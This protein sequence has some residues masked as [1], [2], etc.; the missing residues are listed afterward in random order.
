MARQRTAE[1][2]RRKKAEPG[3]K[4]VAHRAP[5]PM[6]HKVLLYLCFFASGIAG[7]T[8]EIVWSKYLSYLLGNSIYGVAT[9]V[10]AFLGG[11]GLGAVMGGTL[12]SRT[13]EPL[14]MYARLELLVAAMGLLSPLAYLLARPLF[15]SLYGAMGGSGIAF[16]L[17]RFS[18]L[19]AA[20]LIPTIAMGA[21]LPLLVSAFTRREGEFGT[22]V[23]RLYAINTA[24]A[25]CGV[26]LAGFALIPSIG[27]WKAAAVA[28]GIDLLVAAAVFAVKPAPRAVAD[29]GE[30]TGG[31]DASGAAVE[32]RDPPRGAYSPASA[33][34]PAFT[35]LILPAF[36]LSGFCAIL[37]EVAWTRIL[38][39]PFGGMVYSFSSILAVYL[40]GIAL[41]AAL[42]SLLLRRSRAPALLFGLFQLLLA[43]AVVLGSRV[44]ASLPD[45]QAT[46]IAQSRGSAA[47]LFAGEAAVAARIVLLPTFFLGALFPLAAAIYQRARHEAG[48]S[49]G[50]IYAA[51]TL[52]SIAGS[53][54]TGFV[55]IPAIGS[56]RAILAAALANVAIG[57]LALLLGEGARWKRGAAA[58]AAVAGTVAVASF[59]IPTWQSERMS[60]GF[61]RL[62]RAYEFGGE[63]LVHRILEKVGH[64]EELERLLFYKEGRV[65]TVTVLETGDRRALLINGKTDATTGS[66]EDMA[67]Q[68]MVGQVPLLLAPNAKDVCVVGYGSGVTTHAVLTHPI[69]KALTLELEGAVIEAAPFFEAAAYRPLADPR[70]RLVVE[71]AGTYLRSTK[72]NFD[73]I[74][75]EPSNPWI[76]GVGNL[77]TKEFYE[78]A[79]RRLKPGGIFCQWIQTY[80]VSPATL[81]TVL[82]TVAT[83][84]PKG[85]LFYVES[86]GDLIILAV[87]DR[88]LFLDRASMEAVFQRPAVAADFARIGI[89]SIEDVLGAYRGR[90]DR[91]AREAGPGPVNTDDNSWL[92]HEAP[93]DLI[94]PQNENPLLTRSS[95]VEADL[96]SSLR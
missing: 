54:V 10:A 72:E 9:V 28:A 19:F 60:F 81:S 87:P 63:S 27:L 18:V 26:A 32:R 14:M 78:E 13:R 85:Q 86:S 80:S 24:G 47:N 6:R 46:L 22:S 48:A 95:Q 58:A 75:S 66:G 44:F 67:Q 71:D 39:V 94:T 7:L 96:R 79:R 89:H 21:T 90:L 5:Q 68:V 35:P 62:L 20:L 40:L 15:A 53:I 64:S 88:E 12:A 33:D 2:H 17:V 61:V 36:A 31:V 34:T 37:Y 59:A 55:L 30:T 42:A 49:V 73:V 3:S 69:E 41:G 70:S 93:L 38:S 29:A 50:T 51:N 23:S 84:F 77:F 16:L 65:A 83:T 11:L 91:L 8:L 52:G 57:C 76:A 56:F 45:L 92:E 4:R 74:I 43:G 82:R 25:V 1:Q